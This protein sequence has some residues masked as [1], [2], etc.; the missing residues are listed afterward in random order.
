MATDPTASEEDAESPILVTGSTGGLGRHVI[1][2]LLETGI[3][4][5][6]IAALA[7]DSDKATEL[8]ERG[9]DVR[10]G[11]YTEPDALRAALEGIDRLLLI[12]SS[13]V[14]EQRVEQHRNVVE[15]AE[16]QD[17]GFVAYTSGLNA[18][19][20]PMSIAEEHR[21]TE[22]LIRD[23]GIPYTLLRNGMYI[24]N[25]TEQLDQALE[26]GAFVGCANGGRISAA[27]RQDFAEAAVTVLTEEGHK[28]G[29]YELGG[30]EAFTMDELAEEVS[31]QSDTEVVYHDFSQEE[32]LNTLVEQDV[33][34]WQ[35]S[36]LVELDQEIAE[37]GSYTESDDLRRLIGRPTTPLGDAVASALPE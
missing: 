30:D 1:N 15:A 2:Q 12:S 4:S 19:T 17:V 7:R 16:E 29:V 14:G 26:Q 35:A 13:E 36:V 5:S 18:D 34:E 8:D 21:E 32:Y 22:A 28:G 33:P 3:E 6:K 31:Q 11:D 20:S 25:H 9:I 37:G 10:I 24:E 27:T 23:S